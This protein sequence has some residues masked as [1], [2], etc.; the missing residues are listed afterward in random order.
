MTMGVGPREGLVAAATLQMVIRMVVEMAVFFL[1]EI[2]LLPLTSV[3]VE[4]RASLIP[5]G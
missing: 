3:V 1:E 5:L 4:R 2:N